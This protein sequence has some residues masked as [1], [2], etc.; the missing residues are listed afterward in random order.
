MKK[1]FIFLLSIVFVQF[2]NAQS[3]EVTGVVT[4][5]GDNSTLPSV[6]VVV[7]GTTNGTITDIDGNFAITANQGDVLVF[8]F[9]GYKDVEKKVTG[10]RISV[11]LASDADIL[12]EVVMVGYTTMRK[13][14][15]TGA[16]ASVKAEDL[17]KTPAANLDQALQ[18]RAVGVVV[19]ANSGR[20]GAP[21]E[22]RIRGV[23]T[24]NNPSPIYVVDGVM[25]EDISFLS[26]NDIESMEILKDASAS[27]IYG[28]KGANGVILV[29]TK[30]GEAG[31]SNIYINA[32]LGVQNRYKKLEILGKNDH[33][34][35]MLTMDGIENSQRK[36]Y[37]ENGFMA[38]L[39]T[40]RL[41]PPAEYYPFGPFA[42][43]Y[44]T[45]ET[46]WQDE[47]FVKNALIHN[48][49]IG[50][51][52]GTDKFLYSLSGNYFDQTG[53]IIGSFYRRFTVRLNTSYQARKWLKIGENLSFTHSRARSF[54]QDNHA[55]SAASII[56]GALAMAPWDPTHY[57]DETYNYLGDKISGNPAAA[58]NK[59]TEVRNPFTLLEK[60]HPL[61]Y[62]D[63]WFGD[64]YVD[65]T[66]IKGLT[67]RSDFA[68]DFTTIDNRSF[69]EA[70]KLSAAEQYP[71]NS[72]SHSQ[73][74]ILN[75][76]FANTATYAREIG[77]HNFSIMVGHTLEQYRYDGVFTSGQDILSP[78]ERNWFVSKA[79][80]YLNNPSDG[81]GRSR[82]LSYIA[83]AFYSFGDRYIINATFRSD[84]SSKFRTKPWGHFPSIGLAWRISEES[85]MKNVKN[86]DY[87]KMRLG[88][89]RIGNDRAVGD[90]ASFTQVGSSDYSFYAYPF[91]SREV[92]YNGVKIYDQIINNG[93]AILAMGNP[94]LKW[95]TT[96]QYNLGID[97]SIF[98]SKLSGTLDIFQRNTI[99]MILWVPAPAQAGVMF[100]G[101]KNI[102]LVTNK[103]VELSL[104]H[105]NKVGDFNYSIG[106]NISFVKNNLKKRY[107]GNPITDPYSWTD[108]GLPLGSFYGYKYLGVFHTQDEL[109]N[110]LYGY[111]LAGET[112]IYNLGDAIYEDLN[113][114]GK[115]T[116]ADRTFLGSPI[117]TL[118]YG[119]NFSAEWKGID[120]QIFFQGVGGNKVYN[121]MRAGLEG[122][123]IG[124]ALS[125]DMMGKEKGGIGNGVYKSATLPDG[126]TPNPDANINGTIPN[127]YGTNNFMMSSRFIENGAYLRLK[128]VQLGYTV[129][130]KLLK[131]AYI[132][133]MRFYVQGSNIF[134]ITKYKG[135]DPEVGMRGVDYG[136]YP[137]YTT[138]TFGFNLNF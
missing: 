99:G 58:S 136:N 106:G 45:Q 27:A 32:S 107:E 81:V 104:E 28:S 73:E 7:K 111:A 39:K 82:R 23:G 44:E 71:I 61:G 91:G 13:K 121:Q 67:L 65:I 22:I 98:K 16:I 9:T 50:I 117:P 115:I 48:Y 78:I 72:V 35:T 59:K 40:Y 37:K 36:Y 119:L 93:A 87:L 89:G 109:D 94:A 4:D 138:Y 20:P 18:G 128:N 84:G 110:H 86:L 114:D 120:L 100:D 129:P 134:T 51:D 26:P 70:Y 130:A 83:R 14:D 19:N 47:I 29:S 38:W 123:G 75:I 21:A 1:I 137:Q 74:R 6:T 68:F 132:T 55:S 60:A 97:F 92:D 113:N 85:F 42:D 25:V 112:N 66:P 96:E 63:R 57:P 5:A 76:I 49:N 126:V 17:K 131:K 56:S 64:V 103:G 90:N 135:F 24:L 127:P 118:N 41:T 2:A 125:V 46:D 105:R 33:L 108:E 8:S 10:D 69:T 12:D 77:K 52:G 95:E 43:F 11:A 102:G 15:V 80:S 34:K 122:T 133:R 124:C 3:I 30:K 88:W 62:A 79:E 101:T 31:K 53:V 116:D 54:L